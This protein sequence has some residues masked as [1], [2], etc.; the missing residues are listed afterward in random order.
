M[1]GVSSVSE[2]CW[3]VK[4]RKREIK[5][6]T[7][8]RIEAG[9]EQETKDGPAVPPLAVFVETLDMIFHHQ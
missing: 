4:G 6:N 1:K 9:K 5:G 8:R 2:L 7:K 3:R